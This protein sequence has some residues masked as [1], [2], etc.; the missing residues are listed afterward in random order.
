[1]EFSYNFEV[2][3]VTLSTDIEVKYHIFKNNYLFSFNFDNLSLISQQ[4]FKY[5]TNVFIMQITFILE[6]CIDFVCLFIRCALN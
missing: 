3:N 4:I 2:N 1:M 5:Q 6:C